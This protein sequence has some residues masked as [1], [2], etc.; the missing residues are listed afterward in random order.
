VWTRRTE[1]VGLVL[2]GRTAR[3]AGP[4]AAVVGTVVSLV[5]Q[6][7]VLINGHATGITALRMIVNYIVPFI[8]ASLAY[9]SACRMRS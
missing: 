6:G 3:T 9:L 2:R 5:N 8:V 1:A 7:D 4:I